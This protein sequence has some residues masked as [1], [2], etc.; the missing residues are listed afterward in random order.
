MDDA[1]RE[2][3]LDKVHALA[4]KIGYPDAWRD[5]SSLTITKGDYFG[6]ALAARRFDARRD[7]ERIG[8]P[9][10]K[11]EWQ[12]T[13]P[14]VNAYYNG[15]ANEMVFPA[16]IM[17]SP[18]FH[19]DF[20]APMNFGGI[21]LVMGHELTHGFDDRGRKFD[22]KGR[23]EEWWDPSAS[24]K[25]EERAACVVDLYE[26][27]QVQPGVHLNGKLTLGEN[28]ADLGGVKESYRAYHDWLEKHPGPQASVPGLTGDQLF[29]VGFAQTWCTVA[30]PEF[31]RL[32]ATTDSHST[33]RFRVQGPLSNFPAFAQAFHCAEG[34]PMSPKNRC[35]VW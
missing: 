17:Q 13:P 31:E 9:V 3:A 33:A 16:G 2:R 18:F 26:G 20:P 30:S 32:R 12:M 6:D 5:Y 23:L 25:F 29:F 4:N 7:L 22:P 24:R 1:T 14:T 28:I 11:K 10:D 35:E 21:G 27:Y 19:R 34:T 8:K 15:S